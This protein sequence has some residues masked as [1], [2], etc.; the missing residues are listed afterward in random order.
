MNPSA[1]REPG[2]QYLLAGPF[3]IGDLPLA[4]SPITATLAG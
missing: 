2:E 1:I 4:F 3:Q